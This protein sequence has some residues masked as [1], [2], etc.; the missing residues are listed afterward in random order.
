MGVK[1]KA[2]I[3]FDDQVETATISASSEA[4]DV[5]NLKSF[6]LGEKWR[7]TSN[8]NEYVQADFGESTVVPFIAFWRHNLTTQAT[9]RVRISDNSDM[10]SPAFDA[11]FY[12]W[13]GFTGYDEGGYNEGG[14]GGTP[15]I[16]LIDEAQ[17]YSAFPCSI[18]QF[19]TAVGGSV[20]SIILPNKMDAFGYEV[21]VKSLDSDFY[22]G[23]EV[24]IISGTGAGQTI[25]VSGFDPKA[26]TITPLINFSTAPDSTSE[27]RINLLQTESLTADNGTYVG[28]YI[29]LDIDDPNNNSAYIQAG[30]LLAGNY[31]QPEHDLSLPNQIQF[32]DPSQS[33]RSYG[34]SQWINKKNKYRVA[35]GKFSYMTEGEATSEYYRLLQVAGGSKPI[36]FMPY[37]EVSGRLYTD[38]VYG[39]LV[40][41]RKGAGYTQIR[42]GSRQKSYEVDLEV[43][44]LL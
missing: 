19:G 38:T 5:D 15:D 27:I 12:A 7:T 23:A 16:S 33:F 44:E 17:F 18:N 42:R 32:V 20:S 1:G 14:Y 24:T 34:Q 2:T 8:T 28:R 4:I 40:N 21:D 11:T 43:E 10:S 39:L 22:D 3:F 29:R 13:T 41:V 9:I 25:L 6:Q 36:V 37:F 26:K 30:R 31:I 35:K